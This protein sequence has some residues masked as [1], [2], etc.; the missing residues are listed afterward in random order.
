MAESD[1]LLEHLATLHPKSID[2]SL[3]RVE[4]LLAALG[5]PERQLPPV[6]HVAGTNGKGSV[7]AYLRAMH[8]AASQRVHTFTSPHLCRFHERIRLAGNLVGEAQLTD[9]L[10][11]T[12]AANNGAPITFFEITTAAAML[13][14]AETP[15]DILL[16]ETG[17]GGRLD[18]TN[19]IAKP[20]ATVITPVSIDHTGFLG[21]DLAAIAREKA[22]IL[23]PGVTCVVS[24]QQ[25]EAEE[26]I[27]RQSETVGAPLFIE[28]Q[29]WDAFEQQGRLVYQDE[30]TLL[31]LPLPRLRGRHQI[32]NAGAAVAAVSALG[33]SMVDEKAICA[34]LQDASWAGRFERLGPGRLTDLI[35]SESELWLDGGHNP[36]AA[37]VL[38][39]ALADLEERSPRP[40]HLICG[41]MNNKDAEAFFTAFRGLAEYVATVPI[42]GEANAYC[43]KAL[44][45]KV[46]AA[47]LLAEPTTGLTE[48]LTKSHA[49]GSDPVRILICGSLYLAGHV[50]KAHGIRPK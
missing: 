18:A 10:M 41:M 28:G 20:A 23:K 7:I 44:A 11:R 22:G 48:A 33:T 3:G 47:G 5:N 30:Q 40:L 26:A 25:I 19:V 14:F 36:A 32:A 35:G 12:E 16:L 9:I 6:V 24:R 46:E 37:H 34:G 39:E 17:L 2:L 29:D 38:A 4:R 31:D 1:R 50:Y 15:A 8:E 45:D 42:P 13:A 27:E 43:A 49:L 21:D